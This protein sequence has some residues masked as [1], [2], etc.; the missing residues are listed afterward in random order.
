MADTVPGNFDDWVA[1]FGAWQKKVGFDTAWL[2]DYKF[3]AKYD[4]DN[5][6]SE[7]EFGDYKGRP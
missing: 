5:V 1:Q 7:I 6:R 4:Y 2:G 3:E